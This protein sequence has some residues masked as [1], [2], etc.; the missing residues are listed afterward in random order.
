MG[1]T[2]LSPRGVLALAIGLLALELAVIALTWSP[3]HPQPVGLVLVLLGC[4]LVGELGGVVIGGITVSSSL[5]V[6]LLAMA[7]LGP[8]PAAML[9]VL[10]VLVDQAM[11][12]KPAHVV[13]AN[14]LVFSVLCFG[15]GKAIEA[16]VGS[17][18]GDAGQALAPAVFVVGIGVCLLNFVFIAGFRRIATGASFREAAATALLPT[19]PYS[20]VGVTLAAGAVQAHVSAALPALAG[21]V[22]ALL[23]SEL[24]LRSIA[25]SCSRADELIELGREREELLRASLTAEATERAWIAEQLHDETLQQIA[26]VEQELAE[27][28]GDETAAIA[29]ARRGLAAAIGDLRRTLAHAH[30]TAVAD[31]GLEQALRAYADQ[32]CRRGPS[33]HVHV[34]P[35]IDRAGH[36]LLYSLMRE[37]LANAVRHGR[38]DNVTVTVR[39]TID[40][41]TLTVTDDGVGFDP[42]TRPVAGHVGLATIYGRARA[43]GGSSTVISAPGEGTTASVELPLARPDAPV[44]RFGRPYRRSRAVA[45]GAGLDRGAGPE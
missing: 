3:W 12:R 8:V 4:V 31:V 28:G 26:L 40:R 43:A 1:G 19:L 37:L 38:P 44:R 14:V 39:R 33:C 36:A 22:L 11:Y 35:G 7:L 29:S 32:V 13:L 20:V 24:L 18:P 16:L 9:G 42:G 6:L 10:A 23:V 30:P 25:A 41:V 21:V 45:A 15:G 5:L 27:A 17:E 34:D 2:L